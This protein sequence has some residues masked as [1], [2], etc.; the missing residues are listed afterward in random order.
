MNS[1]KLNLD[2]KYIRMLAISLVIV[3]A[4][5]FVQ[6]FADFLDE[7]SDKVV[8]MGVNQHCDPTRSICSASIVNDK[9]FQRLS[10]SIA[11]STA[12]GK[13]LSMMVKA[14]GFDFD[15]IQSIAVSFEMHG[16]TL[17]DNRI[18]FS[19]DKSKHQVVPEEWHAVARLPKAPENRTDWIAVIHLKSSKKEYRAEFPFTAH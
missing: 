18:L 16:E 12:A 7:H 9:E 3:V 19:P 10:F 5:S 1:R 4:L 2:N 11:G 6:D 17:E 15:G 8:K 14:T 13:E